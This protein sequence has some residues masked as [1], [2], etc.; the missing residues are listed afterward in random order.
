MES[1]SA[2]EAAV[3]RMLR[4]V[5]DYL[6]DANYYYYRNFEKYFKIYHKKDQFEYYIPICR[7]AS[8]GPYYVA[9]FAEH[10]LVTRV[11]LRAIINRR[12]IDSVSFNISILAGDNPYNPADRKT[13]DEY[14]KTPPPVSCYEPQYVQELKINE[15]LDTGKSVRH[16]VHPGH[17]LE[18]FL[19]TQPTVIFDNSEVFVR[20]QSAA[21]LGG[22]YDH[23]SWSRGYDSR[24]YTPSIKSYH[25]YVLPFLPQYHTT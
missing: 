19:S 3:D 20:V 2:S 17:Q 4:V 18:L 23:I 8:Q 13:V 7:S 11:G 12:I 15:K 1:V 14:L 9:T 10:L 21:V 16:R 24:G 25:K 6:V 5:P 22:P